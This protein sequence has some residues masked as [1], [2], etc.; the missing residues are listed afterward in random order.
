M[1]FKKV[2]LSALVRDFDPFAD[3]PLIIERNRITTDN[4][5]TNTLFL[6]SLIFV[7]DVYR[8]V[9]SKSKP[10]ET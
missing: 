6:H 4:N 3:I 8:L 1:D 5:Q 2:C 9:F 10:A 7:F